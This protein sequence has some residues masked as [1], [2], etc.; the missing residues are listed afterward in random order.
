[1]VYHSKCALVSI[2]SKKIPVWCHCYWRVFNCNLRFHWKI[3]PTSCIFMKM[4]FCQSIFS[5][6]VWSVTEESTVGAD[7]VPY[8]P[9]FRRLTSMD[10]FEN[11]GHLN[12]WILYIFNITKVNKYFV[13]HLNWCIALPT[14]YK[15]KCPTNK[16]DFTVNSF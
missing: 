14:K 4:R 16:N 3:S 11:R 9:Q 2:L 7:D 5:Q 6:Y 15:I 10:M 13:G 1:L 12:S 8:I